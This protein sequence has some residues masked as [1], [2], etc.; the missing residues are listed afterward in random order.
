MAA[1]GTSLKEAIKQFE[2]AK[3]CNAAEAEKARRPLDS[4][5]LC[6]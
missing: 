4:F 5:S 1:K 6:G 2:A 3:G